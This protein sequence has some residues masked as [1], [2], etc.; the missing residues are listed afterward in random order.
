MSTFCLYLYPGI[1]GCER[2]RS[3]VLQPP[4]VNFFQAAIVSLL[5]ALAAQECRVFNPP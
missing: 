3:A 1:H 4:R 5:A 2:E